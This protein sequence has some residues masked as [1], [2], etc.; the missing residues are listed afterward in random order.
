MNGF[1]GHHFR[2]EM[3]LFPHTSKAPGA[4]TVR[5]LFIGDA[6]GHLARGKLHSSH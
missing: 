6:S 5:D 3:V 4:E 1:R 2:G